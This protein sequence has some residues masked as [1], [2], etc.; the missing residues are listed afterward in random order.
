MREVKTVPLSQIILFIAVTLCCFG[1]T[2]LSEKRL[3]PY[4]RSRAEQPIYTEG[5]SWHIAKSGTP[6][7]GGIGFVIAV[8]ITLSVSAIILNAL[9]QYDAALS[10][11]V[12]LVFA[13]ANAAVGLTDDL[14]KLRRK[15]NAG[16]SPLQ[17]LGLQ[18]LFA[19]AYLFCRRT[20]FGDGTALVFSFGELELGLLY[21]P[22]AL[23]MLLGIIN[24]ANLTDGIDG[25]ASSVAFS[26]GIC[27][28]FISVSGFTDACAIAGA[29]VGASVGFLCFNLNPAKIFMG[30]TGSLFF[31]ALAISAAFSFKNPSAMI[32][33]GGIYVI[34]GIS[35]I[36]QVLFYK[37]TKKRLFKM[38]PL[39]HHLEKSGMSETGICICA[40]ILTLLLGAMTCGLYFSR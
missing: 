4:L 2:V 35:V 24:C 7:M 13:L 3:I 10:L 15:Q 40:M 34:E 28:F 32:P 25:L 16:L 19:L 14:T 12:S 18:L 30:D 21:Y 27:V 20:F 31:G 29:M 36:L 39:H 26:V 33:I 11:T 23:V 6:T 38:A 37:A 8:S 9:G 17:K 22:F 1:L 5:P